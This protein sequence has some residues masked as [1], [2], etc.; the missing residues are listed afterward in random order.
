MLKV[1][2]EKSDLKLAWIR[3]KLDALLKCLPEKSYMGGEHLDEEA[4]KTH[5][6]AHSKDCSIIVA[7]GKGH[8]PIFCPSK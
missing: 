4:W 5:L 1:K 8:V 3:T 2:V 6:D 7:P